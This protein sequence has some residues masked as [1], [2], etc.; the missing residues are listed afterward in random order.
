[1]FK[2]QKTDLKMITYF[3]REDG[4]CKV[5]RGATVSFVQTLKICSFPLLQQ[6]Q[7]RH[8]KKFSSSRYIYRLLEE[9]ME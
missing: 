1:M 4:C 2:G 8:S 7:F 5:E 9:D 3:Q 6:K